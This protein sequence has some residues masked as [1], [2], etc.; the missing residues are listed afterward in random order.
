[1]FDP[2]TSPE[3][4]KF[5]FLSPMLLLSAGIAIPLLFFGIKKIGKIE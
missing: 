1:M 3:L 5:Y 4:V 2:S